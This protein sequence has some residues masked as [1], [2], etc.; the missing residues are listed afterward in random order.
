MSL[1]VRSRC[2]LLPLA[3]PALVLLLG[4]QGSKET[5]SE[6]VVPS[7]TQGATMEDRG[8]ALR[9]H[10]ELVAAKAK[11]DLLAALSG[12]LKEVLQS[13]G[14][15]AAIDVCSQEALTIADQ[16]GAKH[17][18]EIGRTSYKLRNAANAPREW[19]KPFVDERFDLPKQ[20]SLEN[21]NLGVLFPIHLDVKCLMCHGGPD[22]VLDEVK[23][24]LAKRYPNDQATGFQQGDLR[25]WFW[26]EV[27]ADAS[28]G[29]G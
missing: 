4:C 11:D 21:G 3:M 5:S 8:P 20:V 10:R 19:V 12:R 29:P 25:G 6:I 13:K 15:A 28:D 1:S 14:A 17:G 2:L 22:D 18:V 7:S 9:D 27:P 16:V 24:E 23:S 26:V